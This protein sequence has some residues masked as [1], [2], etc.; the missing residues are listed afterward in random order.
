MTRICF[1]AAL[2][3]EI[4]QS[5]INHHRNQRTYK[6][7][8]QVLKVRNVVYI[9]TEFAGNSIFNNTRYFK[10]TWHVLFFNSAL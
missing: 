4:D 6:I 9:H 1:D 7:E 10:I 3:F 8:I 2:N 5:N